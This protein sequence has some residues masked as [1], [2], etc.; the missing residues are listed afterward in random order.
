VQSLNIEIWVDFHANSPSTWQD[1]SIRP[2]LAAVGWRINGQAACE[3]QFSQIDDLKRS[4][5]IMFLFL[6]VDISL[7]SS[8]CKNWIF[9]GEPLEALPEKEPNNSLKKSKSPSL[10]FPV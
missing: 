9:A 5:A 3:D 2:P 4:P 1:Y 8:T 6:Q 7:K 10:F